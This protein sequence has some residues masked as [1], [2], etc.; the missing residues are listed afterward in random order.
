MGIDALLAALWKL[1][2]KQNKNSGHHCFHQRTLGSSSKNLNIHT[3]LNYSSV[4]KDLGGWGCIT[5]CDVPDCIQQQKTVSDRISLPTKKNTDA[6]THFLAQTHATQVF[7][8]LPLPSS[9][10][11]IKSSRWT[12][13]GNIQDLLTVAIRHFLI[14]FSRLFNFDGIIKTYSLD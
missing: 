5:R 9:S 6:A 3:K 11:L 10:L 2:C 13:I 12:L 8:V 4:Y 7:I 1:K 14:Q